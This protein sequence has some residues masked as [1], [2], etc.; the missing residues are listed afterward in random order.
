MRAGW[1]EPPAIFAGFQPLAERATFE[2]GLAGVIHHGTAEERGGKHCQQ[3]VPMVYSEGTRAA[4]PQCRRAYRPNMHNLRCAPPRHA[5]AK[6]PG[7]KASRRNYPRTTSAMRTTPT[8][9]TRAAKSAGEIDHQTDQ[10][11]QTKTAAADD[12]PAEVKPAAAK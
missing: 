5:H 7:R 1:A 12:G 11:D 3:G 10:Q 6:S 4:L 2:L 8:L 9:T